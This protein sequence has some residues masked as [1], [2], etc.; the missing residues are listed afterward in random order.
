M[1]KKSDKTATDIAPVSINLNHNISTLWVDVFNINTR[2]DN[3]L[4]IRFCANLPEGLCEQ[5][6]IMTSKDNIKGFI[7]ILCS[8]LNYYPTKGDVENK[9]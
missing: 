5:A 2:E 8:N 3:L 7:D 6:K 9:H 4:L 1:T